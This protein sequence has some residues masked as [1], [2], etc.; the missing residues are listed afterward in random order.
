MK[1]IAI[2]NY[3]QMMEYTHKLI[4]NSDNAFDPLVYDLMDQINPRY[5]SMLDD[6]ECLS[7][8]SIN[9]RDPDERKEAK[10]CADRGSECADAMSEAMSLYVL[11]CVAMKLSEDEGLNGTRFQVSPQIM[12]ELQSEMADAFENMK[13][14]S[15][16]LSEC[17]AELAEIADPD[18]VFSEVSDDELSEVSDENEHSEESDIADDMEDS[19][20][21]DLS[22]QG[23]IDYELLAER[24][25]AFNQGTLRINM[26]SSDGL[27]TENYAERLGTN[28]HS[29]EDG[30]WAV[31]TVNSMLRSLYGER[32]Y[33]QM[34]RDGADMMAGIYI[35]GEPASHKYSTDSYEDKCCAFMKEVLDGGHRVN[36][37]RMEKGDDGEYRLTDEI[38]PVEVQ[39]SL[40]AKESWWRKLLNFFGIGRSKAQKEAERVSFAALSNDDTVERI[41]GISTENREYC[42]QIQPVREAQ[43]KYEHAQSMI[44]RYAFRANLTDPAKYFSGASAYC[45]PPTDKGSEK[46]QVITTLG[47]EMTRGSLVMALA[48]SEGITFEQLMDPD[49]EVQAR[50][51]ATGQRFINT[52]TMPTPEEI[53]AGENPNFGNLP[54]Q[55]KD[56][57]LRTP[58][59]RSKYDEAISQKL[60]GLSEM[61]SD[62]TDALKEFEGNLPVIDVNDR[63]SIAAGAA[64]HDFFATAGCDLFQS[65][66]TG[67]IRRDGRFAE[68]SDYGNYAKVVSSVRDLVRDMA[69]STLTNEINANPALVCNKLAN[70]IGFKQYMVDTAGAARGVEN[71]E[72]MGLAHM[73]AILKA[74]ALSASLINSEDPGLVK[75]ARNIA[76]GKIPLPQNLFTG[77]AMEGTMRCHIGERFEQYRQLN[78]PEARL[79]INAPERI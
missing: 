23:E 79:E 2:E 29:A 76:S 26:H 41:R 42:A 61:Y 67:P 69:D 35:D 34:V 8:S 32:R 48:L 72:R 27:T 31:D 20:E 30:K 7:D 28:N 60:D 11:G 4:I 66:A 54:K 19:I 58:G 33:N 24:A 3:N 64:K 51:K 63:N 65:L 40:V 49:K 52:V 56:V 71:S 5:H 70:V 53:A 15:S 46:E 45:L 55:M 59:F 78:A 25:R 1:T 74:S 39:P 9:L 77:S 62:I 18:Y 10:A 68:F 36:A 16:E 17:L 14:S 22:E 47:R 13:N 38:C 12:E 44:E 6:L 37:R 43:K 50:L 21:I 73:E 75:Y 57:Y